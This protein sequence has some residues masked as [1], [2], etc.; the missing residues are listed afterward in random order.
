MGMSQRLSFAAWCASMTLWAFVM[1]G[2]GLV[3]AV[4]WPERPRMTFPVWVL[5]LGGSL[6]IAAGEFVFAVTASRMFPDANP[7]LTGTVEVLPIV[8]FLAVAV[9]VLFFWNH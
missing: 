3:I 5:V 6:L 4:E 1:V 9:G 8:G 2:F 7:R